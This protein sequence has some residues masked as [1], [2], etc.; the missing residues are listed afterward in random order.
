MQSH[1]I[2]LLLLILLVGCSKE[3]APIKGN[4]FIKTN[5]GQTLKLALVTVCLFNEEQV[6]AAVEK[7]QNDLSPEYNVLTQKEKEIESSALKKTKEVNISAEEYTKA[8][9]RVDELEKTRP[10]KPFYFETS[11]TDVFVTRDVVS[12]PF[13]VSPKFKEKKNKYEE[14]ELKAKQAQDVYLLRA[15]KWREEYD[16]AKEQLENTKKNALLLNDQLLEIKKEHLLYLKRLAGWSQEFQE[17]FFKF[18]PSPL[19]S[20]KSDADG[21]F[22]FQN[23]PRTRLAIA[24]SSTRRVMDKTENYYWF[25]YLPENITE[26]SFIS[27]N[28]ETLLDSDYTNSVVR[29]PHIPK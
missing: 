12:E 26:T 27:L 14:L 19:L 22:S 9:E 18:L 8:L 10:Q 25:F 6:A 11:D 23:P 7:A 28:N 3:P 2:S 4:V 21:N 13:T 5:G 20:A 17:R 24:A 1:L 29:I 16:L 15:T